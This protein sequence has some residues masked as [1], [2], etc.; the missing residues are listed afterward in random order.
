MVHIIA[1]DDDTDEH[2]LGMML[3]HEDGSVNPKISTNII[4]D[5]NKCADF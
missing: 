3:D 5:D 4:G 2:C 1:L